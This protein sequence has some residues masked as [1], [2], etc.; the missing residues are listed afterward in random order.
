MNL[1]N[2]SSLKK[3]RIVL[4]INFSILFF[5]IVF[6]PYFIKVGSL[7]LSESSVE[8]I[9]LAVEVLVLMKLVRNYDFYSKYL[10]GQADELEKR[11]KEQQKT[12]TDSLEYLGKV[13]V[14]I[15]TVKKIMNKLKFPSSKN[16]LDYVLAEMSKSLVSLSGGMDVFLRIVDLKTKNTVKNFSMNKNVSLKK[17]NNNLLLK[18]KRLNGGILIVPSG[19]DNFSLKVFAIFQPSEVSGSKLKIDK[20]HYELIQAIVNQCEIV[21][22]LFNSRYY[23]ENKK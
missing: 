16:N 4:W 1:I 13:N 19:Y 18:S 15:S 10:E 12:L 9:F 6:T 5:F 21:Y 14:Q 7:G 2:L 3:A 8:G 20:E 17:I 22:L 11:L 23:R